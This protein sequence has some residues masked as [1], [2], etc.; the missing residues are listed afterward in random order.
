MK[1]D[2]EIS[3][4]SKSLFRYEKDYNNFS[5]GKINPITIYSNDSKDVYHN[6]LL[7]SHWKKIY[8]VDSC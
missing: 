3:I 2:S 8:R 7:S 1:N 4:K 6:F 5:I